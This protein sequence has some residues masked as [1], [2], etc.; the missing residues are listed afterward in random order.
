MRGNNLS[1]KCKMRYRFEYGILILKPIYMGN[2]SQCVEDVNEK[3]K[4]TFPG[5]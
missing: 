4:C 3:L 5:M 2:V 1:F